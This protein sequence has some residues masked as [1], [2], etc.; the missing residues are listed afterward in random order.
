VT[1]KIVLSCDGCDVETGPHHLPHREFRSF[2]GRGYGFGVWHY[3][4]LDD[5][6][7]PQG[8]IHSDPITGLTYCPDCWAYIHHSEPCEAPQ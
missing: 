1:V 2:T 6:P 7:F 5:V 8:W 4:G 3:P